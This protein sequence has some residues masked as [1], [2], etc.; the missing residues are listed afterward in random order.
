[1]LLTLVLCALAA[2]AAQPAWLPGAV[3]ARPSAPQLAWEA[4]QV[5]LMITWN[6]QSACLPAGHANASSQPCQAGGYL[7]T[8]PSLASWAPSANAS[9]WLAIGAS[10]GA[11]YAVLVA[12]HFSGFLLWP[13]ASG[14]PSLADTASPTPRNL[15][16][17]FASAAAR[18]GLAAGYFYSVHCNWW[19]GVNEFEAGHA[20][21]GSAGAPLTPAQFDA[22]AAAQLTEL[23]AAA[24]AA[25]GG[26]P[27][28]ELW[29]DA[30]VN[31]SLTPSIA[32]RVAAL[33]P[34]AVCH[35][36]AG[37]DQRAGGGGVGVRWMGNEEAV[38]PL[39]NWG[40]VG[41]GYTPYAGDPLGAIYAPASCD[42]VLSEHHW[43]NART[44]S[45]DRDIRS[46]CSLASAYLTSVGR[47]CNLILNLAPDYAGAVS[48]AARAAYAEL[49][50]AAQCLHARPLG[51]AANLTLFSATASPSGAAE[52]AL[53]AP[54]PPEP[55]GAS[56]HC[57]SL[58]LQLSERTAESGQRIGAWGVA[59]CFA[60]GGCGSGGG[61]WVQLTGA[62]TPI[63]ANATVGIGARR[64]VR[65]A[66]AQAAAP[67]AALV[68]LRVAVASAY[69][70]GGAGG[71]APG[72]ADL[73]LEHL[74]LFDWQGA[75]GCAPGC[76][77]P[78]Y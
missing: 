11:K 12:D 32:A 54:L 43:F 36:C 6:L 34:G 24:A 17:A 63:P 49:G 37:L 65:L 47:G 21:W 76:A 7:P 5:G 77:L 78:L 45:Y 42:T 33:A 70:W 13:S 40:A 41:A 39:P 29:F 14:A 48:P 72:R 9:D 8:L 1:M 67:G 15:V 74:Q 53:P 23:L 46:V 57:W 10:F 19:A 25:P 4:R 35:S 44:M 69:P 59:G 38:M 52:W 30:G 55:C 27:T 66:H 61:Q 26:A 16:A 71:A 31:A 3:T 18:A 28:S 50:A 75:Q 62:A 20:R 51:A 56:Q 22:L 2:C 64:W 60:A 73:V 58:G 68:A